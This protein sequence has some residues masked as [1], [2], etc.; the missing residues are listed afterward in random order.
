MDDITGI[1]MRSN[2]YYLTFEHIA[3]KYYYNDVPNYSRFIYYL[4]SFETIGK[5][6]QTI[7]RYNYVKK[8][9]F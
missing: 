7:K 3:C 6:H 8:D 9:L 2:Y 1:L 4:S 5:P